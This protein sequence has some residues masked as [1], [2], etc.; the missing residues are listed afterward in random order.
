[1]LRAVRRGQEEDTLA[2]VVEPAEAHDLAPSGERRQ[3]KPVCD[4]FPHVDRS[5]VTMDLPAPRRCATGTR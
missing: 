4:P 3:R 5:G 1:M 2:V